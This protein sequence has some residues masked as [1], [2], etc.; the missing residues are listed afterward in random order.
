MA[1]PVYAPP[2][3]MAVFRLLKQAWRD[4]LASP[5]A[6]GIDITTIPGHAAISTTPVVGTVYVDSLRGA[7]MPATVDVKPVQGAP[8]ASVPA[9]VNPTTGAYSVTLAANTFVAGAASVTV[10][11]AAPAPVKTQSSNTFTMA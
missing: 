9:T 8:K 11:S 5:A 6:I 10:T 4:Y 1:V 2:H 7:V 3:T